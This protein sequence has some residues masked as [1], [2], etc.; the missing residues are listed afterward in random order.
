MAKTNNNKKLDIPIRKLNKQSS[1]NIMTEINEN[2]VSKIPLDYLEPAPKEWNFYDAYSQADMS[3]L[4]ESIEEVGLL[5]PIIVYDYGDSS[6][7]YMILSGHNRVNAFK[8]LKE[9][10][11]DKKYYAIDAIIKTKETLDEEMAQ[12][13]IIDTNWVQRE[14]TTMQKAKSI[15]RKYAY[16][17]NN[18]KNRININDIIATEY[19]IS[20]RQVIN[21]K[22]L[23]SLLSELQTAIDNGDLSIKAG[24]KI[25]DLSKEVQA[26]IFD[27][28]IS[29][30]KKAVV[31]K[32]YKLLSKDTTIEEIEE[33]FDG[34][35]SAKM[36]RI[37][38]RYPDKDNPVNYKKA[39][40]TY[41]LEDAK[42]FYSIIDAF[43]NGR[44]DLVMIEDDTYK[45]GDFIFDV[46][47]K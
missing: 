4:I 18:T 44:H 13:I 36:G 20:K 25:G 14:L 30:G 38:I 19:G 45:E 6:G 11:D 43:C 17:K 37:D 28:Y 26:Y 41:P 24:V 40:V 27:N 23:S 42:Y 2:T 33:L 8:H 34:K 31:N 5:N 15:L 9:Y 1:I 29:V 7:N 46:T 16:I 12:Q 3:K 10:T 22:S 21:Y 35:K 47:V 39:F 32:N